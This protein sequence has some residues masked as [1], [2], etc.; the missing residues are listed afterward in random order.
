MGNKLKRVGRGRG[1]EVFSRNV[2]H[3]A[4]VAA[5]AA[6]V[7][8]GAGAAT[9]YWDVNGTAAGSGGTGIW[10]L[11]NLSWGPSGDGT[12]GPFASAWSNAALDDAI[13]GGTAGT[14]TLGAPITAHNLGFNTSGY[15]LTGNTLSLAGASPTI[16]TNMASTGFAR[17]ASII[18]GTAG[19]TKAGDGTLEL[20]NTGNTF[21]GGILLTGGTLH[22]ASDAALGQ[23]G[24][25]ITTAAGANV[26][27]RIDGASTQRSVTIGNGGNLTLSGTGVGSARISG[28]GNVVVTS[29]LAGGPIVRLSNNASNYTGTTTFNGITG[30]GIAEF[31]SIAD[32]GQASALGAPTTV[33]NGTIYVNQ[34]NQYSD[35]V[36]YV[37]AG[38]SSNRNWEI[39][40]G[41]ANIRNLGTGALTL[42]GGMD[43]RNG[44]G[45]GI[46]A[47]TADINLAGVLAGAGYTFRAEPGRAITITGA[48]TF[49]GVP[50][51]TGLVRVSTLAD[52][53]AASALGVANQVNL[54]DATLSYTGGATRSD[55]SW[56]INGAS[57]LLINGTSGL[58]LDGGVA[59]SAGAP[60]PDSLTLGGSYAGG[61]TISGVISGNGNLNV[62]D[63]TQWTL[64]R[65][66]TYTGVTT[67]TQG[68]ALAVNTLGNGGVASGLGAAS[69][70]AA[71]IVLAG[72]KLYYRGV[73][74]SSDRA[75]TLGAG[76]GTLGVVSGTSA[77]TLTGALIG[78]SLEKASSGTL[79]LAGANTYKDGTTVSG[80][81]LQAGA[82]N[83]F[84]NGDMTVKAGTL[85]DLAGYNNQV[86]RF[87]G[88]GNVTLGAGTLTVTGGGLFSGPISGS[89][90][91]TLSGTSQPTLT[92]QGCN[93]T[94]TGATTINAGNTLAVDCLANAGQAS[95]IGAASSLPGNLVLNNGT[96][97][98]TG[99][100]VL[101]NRGFSLLA[102]TGVIDVTNA[103]TTLAISGPV[104]GAGQLRKNGAGTLLLAG[105]NGATGGTHVTN[106]ILRAGSSTALSSGA[107]RLDNAAG[108]ALE[109]GGY[110][111]SVAYL[112]GGGSLGG[113]VNVE[114]AALTLSSGSTLAEANYAG[115]IT[116]NGGLIKA[117]AG[118][119]LL[120]GCGSSYA[121]PTTVQGGTLVVECL[122][123]GG[124]NSSIGASTS[125]ASNLVLDGGT[126][127]YIGSGG[128]TDRLITWSSSS[129]VLDASGTGAIAFT[130]TGP[131][132]FTRPNAFSTFTLSGTNT[133]DNIFSA[134][135]SNNGTGPGFL[136]KNGPG[137]WILGNTASS[138]GGS[139]RINGGVLGV[140]K[141]SDTGTASSIGSNGAVV[142]GD[143]ATLRYLGSGD[144]S[145]RRLTVSGGTST[146]ESSGTG[147]VN[148]TDTGALAL[149]NPGVART[150]V[151]GGTNA[152]LNV[153]SGALADSGA[154]VSTLEKNGAGTWALG[155]A[156][157]YTGAT[158]INAGTLFIGAG[159]TSG[160]I[161]S[162]VVNNAGVL[163]FNRSDS[164][165]F[166][167]QVVGTGSLLQAGSGTTVLTGS[168]IHSGGTTISSGTLQLGDGG[169]SGW[170][171]G[172]VS[173]NGTLAFNRSDD[174]GFT[175][176]VSGNGSLAQRGSGVLTL[177]GINSYRGGTVVEGGTLR[178]ASD[179]NLGDAVGGLTID[180]GTLNTTA[181]ISSNRAVTLVG[182]GTLLTDAA[183]T[184][185]LGGVVAG[186]GLVKSGAGTLVL[187]GTNSYTGTTAVNA[188]TLLVNGNQ[189]AASGTTT[190][191]SGAALGGTGTIGGDVVVTS[192]ASIN[193]GAAGAMPGVLTING[194]LSLDAGAT[195][196]YDFGQAN[197]VGGALN[198]L[199]NVNGDLVAGG[200]LN[201]TTTAG[202]NFDAGIYRVINYTGNRS[203]SGLL[204]GSI[205]SSTDFHIQNS[206]DH[207]V[208]LINTNGQTLRFWDG[209][210]GGRNDGVITGGTGV[211]QNVLGNDNWTDADGAANVP[212][213]NDYFAVFQGAAGL[214]SVDGS[215]GPV[216]TA[217][218]QFAT[219]GYGI[220]G[221][222]LALSGTQAVIRVGD[223]TAAGAGY[224]ATISSELSGTAQLV[225]SDAGTL[226]LDGINSY[227]GGTL[228]RGGVLQVSDD[229]NLGASAGALQLDG[230]ALHATAS[231]SSAR[232]VTLVGDA[233]FDVDAAASLGFTSVVSGQGGLVKNGAGT[234]V[235][236]GDAAYMGGTT[237]AAG[238][239]QLGNGG[240][241]GSIL[242]NVTN[243]GTLVFDR[244]DAVGFSGVV[245]G[246][247][248]LVKNGSGT[249]ILTGANTYTGSTAVSAGT[250]LVNGDQSAAIGA[251]SVGAGATLGG[252][253]SIGG[254]V[255]IAN[256]GTLS[257]GANGIGTLTI[258]GNLSLS[259]G[260]LLD[261]AFG[262]RNSAGGSLNDLVVVK[263][264]LLLDGTID[265]SLTPGGAFDAGV[266]R[267]FNYDGALIDNGLS[268]G[269]LP[270]GGQAV[271]QTAIAGQVNLVNTAGL[272]LNFWDGS[273][274]IPHNDVV[275]GGNGVWQGAA[276]NA[277]W[278]SSTG[279]VNAAY[280]GGA[281]A[282]FAGNAGTVDVDASLGG[283]TANGLQFATDGYLI[284]GDGL[285]LGGTDA[286][287]R[288]GDGTTAGAGMTATVASVLDGAARLVKADA[289]T[290][291]LAGDN[292]YAGGTLI[293]SGT[294]QL[295]NGGTTGS[296]LGDVEND[297]TL[298]FDRSDALGFAGT[299]SGSGALVQ[300]GSGVLTLAGMNSYMGGTSV[301]GGTLRVATDANLGDA[302]GGL[303]LS[304]GTLNTTASF[305]S[306]RALTLTGTG[307][308]IT[309]AATT[310]ELTGALAGDALIK[311]GAGT[312]VLASDATYA[313]G[314]TI[315]AGTMQLGNGGSAGSILGNVINNGSLVFERAD[316]LD[317]SGVVQGTGNLVKNGGGTL[318][319]TGNNAYTGSTAVNAGTLLVNGDQTA[320]TGLTSVNAGATLGG[321]GT[322]GG[323]VSI[324]SGAS[325]NP[326][327]AGAMPGVLTIN[328]QLSLDASATLNYD[329]GQAN[330]VGGALNDL[331]NVNGD[332]VA[333]G[334]L[335]VATTAGGSFDAG[336]YR[337]INYTGTLSGPGLTM[338]SIPS[339]SDFHL[340]TSVDHQVNLINTNGQ[341]LRFWDGGTGGRNDGVITGGSGV[342]QNAGGNDNW[343]I[344]DGSMNVPFVDGH[345][346]L[347]QGQSGVVTIDN[348]PGAVHAAGLQFAVDGYQLNGDSLILD[349]SQALIR[350]G[351]GTQVGAGYTATISSELAG[352]AQLVKA[353]AG[354]LVLDGINSYGGGTLVRGGTL[355]ISDDRNLGAL[356]GG[357]SLDAA[358]LRVT[359]DVASARDV[360]LAGAG[361][362]DVD[363]AATLALSGVMSGPGA[364]TKAGAG[365]LVL[366]G[367]GGNGGGRSI[368][369]GTVLVNG[370]LAAAAGTTTV[371]AGAM[372]G[373]TG[374]LGG[375]VSIGDGGILSPGAGGTGTLTLAGNLSLASGAVLNYQF[376]QADVA[377]GALNDL[378]DVHGNLV[379]DGTLNVSQ[380]A[381]GNFGSGIYRV[382]NYGGALTDNGLSLGVSPAGADLSVQ[383]S[384][385]GQVNLVNAAGLVLNFWDG[386][387]GPKFD[388][389]VNGGNGSWHVG[390]TDRNWADDSGRFNAA[391]ANGGFAIFAGNA[392]TVTVDNTAGAVTASGMQ[393]ASDGYVI[394]G[395]ALTLL[396]PQSTIRVGDG[397]SA[398]AGYTATITAELA[399][400][401]TQ[402]L[403]TDA[404]TLVLAADNTYGGGTAI[405]GGTLQIARDANLG[406]SLAAL[407]IDGGTLATSASLTSNRAIALAG[408]GAINTAT[409]TSFTFGGL[410]SGL[411][412][413]TKQG[414]G[415]LSVVGDNASHAG[416]VVVSGGTLSVHSRLGGHVAVGVDGRLD[417]TGQVGRLSNAGMV[418][419]GRDGQGTLT[420]LG[421]YLGEG[422]RLQ[423]N[424]ALGGDASATSQLVV[425]GATAGNTVVAVSNRGGLGGQ[426]VNGIKIIDVAGVSAGEFILAGDYEFQGHQAV[427]AGAYAYR[428]YKNGVADPNDGDW[429]LRSSLSNPGEPVD[430]GDNGPLY[431]PGVPVYEGYGQTLLALN[432]LPTLQQRVGNRMFGQ[433]PVGASAG[434][435]GRY[436]SGTLNATPEVSTTG[437]RRRTD[438]WKM[439][440]G[441]D[442]ITAEHE[443]G[444]ASIGGFNVH[445]GKADTRITSGF[446]NGTLRT[447]SDGVGASYTWYGRQGM[448]LDAQ[449]QLN[450]FSTN[451]R[452]SVLG[453][454]ARGNK[455]V[456]KAVSIELGRRVMTGSSWAIT[457]QFQVSYAQVDFDSYV[458]RSQARV[459][460]DIGNR[461]KTRI[462]IAFDHHAS[463][464]AASGDVRA[465]RFYGLANVSYDW[466]GDARVNVDGTPV[467]SRDRR[468]TMELGGGGSYSWGN[469][470]YT[471]FGE[472]AA[473]TP[474]ADFGQSHGLK[475]IVG[476]RTSF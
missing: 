136:V 471:L 403:K 31:T 302:A 452:S 120:S 326:G 411:G 27:L 160:S 177:S 391:Y 307:T 1:A 238:T 340:Q 371:A 83:V 48:N 49:T 348:G 314:T 358:A 383:T 80:G 369:A 14:V 381:G 354:T 113:G 361:V 141:L 78:T 28:S 288:V 88:A 285:T 244:S 181:D 441:V 355:Q 50:T 272:T 425:N 266:Y 445:H 462:G 464:E 386:A 52:S 227:S 32:L 133:G 463:R 19:L 443:D 427:V 286:V 137:T 192:G 146:L 247:G 172:N 69:N 79:V 24:N 43:V 467:L 265:V 76:G 221:A 267:I 20:T 401:G 44:G 130:N 301:N 198:D 420:V 278:T 262:Q 92:L 375:D 230:G 289:G 101:T 253:G 319:L 202:G 252:V 236:A 116:G 321:R 353:D 72:G 173:N 378:V 157:T 322:L 144:S 201:V 398:G 211:W 61:S 71:N 395:G 98:Y 102:G 432:G 149:A 165:T 155:G 212:F 388:G 304:G 169:T 292:T 179:A 47:V 313:G 152:G 194:S 8:P 250:L 412:T 25:A 17:I 167:G 356:A 119:Q 400:A 320:A 81:T 351:D 127:Q 293:A 437:A 148:F 224:T 343:T 256:G 309:D 84:G 91:L 126:L 394:D 294:L 16:T 110:S 168:N 132:E 393:F 404:G 419:A 184:L 434:I 34:V 396:G 29:A 23:V 298:V 36:H 74:G 4:L 178:V 217:G 349:G 380:S 214:V 21:S 473:E 335:N 413:L 306:G 6:C 363:A 210:A 281:F 290:L 197:V 207:Q 95:G 269:S 453:T 248:G 440:V 38:N 446:G 114:G 352:A 159:G 466:Q 124:S 449:A 283:I 105:V 189:A 147:A 158:N 332:L 261:Y 62:Q 407:S 385:V 66:N 270:V 200:T 468:A 370:N 390:G 139:T 131:V 122:A 87:N 376:G 128:S 280:A 118:V 57:S 183:T 13:F 232:A 11:T 204:L 367:T 2:L 365:M 196:N 241:T 70:A 264:N 465:T 97:A 333:G 138:Y 15:I 150:L 423:I 455:G 51:L 186:G 410:F 222:P 239:L 405:N 233:V 337:V 89:G 42:T 185:E 458:D 220:A 258:G 9:R 457:P 461:L 474:V 300:Q 334:T 85:L 392:G 260:S 53:G 275:D 99:S 436:D 451:M 296:V 240:T 237:V 166:G 271:V 164:Y 68:G 310:L 435:W 226:V 140:L 103:A 424:T 121:G 268:I 135:L 161:T 176:V 359:A 199:I 94:Y 5:L 104:S 366:S 216:S 151:L 408:D 341:A 215:L 142:I 35:G 346:A 406:A 456:G 347:F 373:G 328:G 342:W 433:T 389:E 402:L 100:S 93:N 416:K 454:L 426:T 109:L 444:S 163:G 372:L 245:Q 191:A 263:G 117:G 287:V 175:D 448:Y 106:G 65:L 459:S 327:A 37:G 56:V 229:R 123:N 174:I 171:L 254:D 428:L 450:L 475:A 317:F 329:F 379:L 368:E 231:L 344:L 330:V 112:V 447:V 40:G 345:F 409:G 336:I 59:F 180:A 107:F 362:F 315:T 67:V 360:S 439:Q 249:L 251:T 305:S 182:T 324:A 203:G 311:S 143:T 284:R 218:M 323:D 255:T 382:F 58:I 422:G 39:T 417:G 225:K 414:A 421:D 274:G 73:T 134:Q 246:T 206:I 399:G 308:L 276:G 208:N 190:V 3:R 18:A 115:A 60:N 235:L 205:P 469:G 460:A 282:V 33:A 350:V 64:S 476:F 364:L 470:A 374:S 297:G 219:D 279:A 418:V 397:S 209:A 145:N 187:T 438:S 90:G 295:G 415:V 41:S 472:V 129:A 243:N 431:Q 430:P 387:A 331:I 12:T 154:G 7:I 26:D 193:P 277:N 156:N 273:S 54:T 153:L 162:A 299:L 234:L 316:A 242:G 45:L 325:I 111:N 259:S 303:S 125:A 30:V 55:R 442:V 96:L 228:I 312:L 188:G 22:G 357:L 429:Y 170:L 318:T 377:G 338:G 10:N 75:M 223:G 384:V 46:T 86:A 77:L 82:V 257:P 291:V 195:L 63:G 339:S 108:A 213:V